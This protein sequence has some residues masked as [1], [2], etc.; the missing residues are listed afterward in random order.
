MAVAFVADCRALQ[1]VAPASYRSTQVA[2]SAR[3][4]D[5]TVR[6]AAQRTNRGRFARKWDYAGLYINNPFDYH[7]Q[8]GKAARCR[9]P[10][11]SG[12]RRTS[13]CH[14]GLPLP[15]RQPRHRELR[16]HGLAL[17]HMLRTRA[18]IFPH[19]PRLSKDGIRVAC[20]TC[21]KPS[22]RVR[23]SSDAVF[24]HASRSPPLQ[25]AR[26]QRCS[27]SYRLRLYEAGGDR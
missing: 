6:C 24:L 5:G 27:E 22:C 21:Q 8:L 2:G 15:Y 7:Y 11:R 26:C 9:R 12:Q 20:Y 3:P 25:A 10:D 14:G 23:G 17:T 18:G 1:P 16:E 4:H 13:A 19:A